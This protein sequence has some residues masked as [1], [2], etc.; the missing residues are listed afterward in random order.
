LNYAFSTISADI[1]L[2]A[3]VEDLTADF[4]DGLAMPDCAE[5]PVIYIANAELKI[6]IVAADT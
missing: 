1:V 5:T 2:G 3:I 6:F 4:I